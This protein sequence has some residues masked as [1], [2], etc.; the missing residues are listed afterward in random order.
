MGFAMA[1][2]EL[3]GVAAHALARET[4]AAGELTFI[5]FTLYCTHYLLRECIANIRCTALLTFE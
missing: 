1:V 3:L 5:M 4:A 2:E